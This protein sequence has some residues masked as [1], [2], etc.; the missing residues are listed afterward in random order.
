MENPNQTI[1]TMKKI[2]LIIPLLFLLGACDTTS[3][4]EPEVIYQMTVQVTSGILEQYYERRV[5]EAEVLESNKRVPA[6][7][8]LDFTQYIKNRQGGLWDLQAAPISVRAE[9]NF[10]DGTFTVLSAFTDF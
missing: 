3:A 7:I 10:S 5:Y 8:K 4:D 9:L 2:L 1:K 6:F